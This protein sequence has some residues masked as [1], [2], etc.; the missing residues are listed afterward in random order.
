MKI[1]PSIIEADSVQI[2][3]YIEQKKKKYPSAKA[4]IRIDED[5]YDGLV[6]LSNATKLTICDLASEMLRFAKERTTI[7]EKS[8][9][10]GEDNG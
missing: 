9:V 6:S 3:I 1:K 10:I 8:V 2:K 5:V 7:I 4:V